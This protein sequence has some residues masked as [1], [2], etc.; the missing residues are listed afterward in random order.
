MLPTQVNSAIQT[1]VFPTQNIG[2]I[3]QKQ[4]QIYSLLADAN[5]PSPTKKRRRKK[6]TKL[7]ET[8]PVMIN[9]HITRAAMGAVFDAPHY[10]STIIPDSIPSS[11]PTC[12]SNGHSLPLR[13]F[14]DSN[15]YDANNNINHSRIPSPSVSL[16]SSS[17]TPAQ[18][19]SAWHNDT[20]SV[21][22][23]NLM[24]QIG[25]R[26]LPFRMNQLLNNNTGERIV[27][28][29]SPHQNEHKH[30]NSNFMVTDQGSLLGPSYSVPTLAASVS[31]SAVPQKKP[32][33]S[34][35]KI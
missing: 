18:Q 35:Q 28:A 32:K 1:D 30:L 20:L 12:L 7:D 4:P 24:P 2:L 23:A 9:P 11:I 25:T 21:A 22:N 15:S 19:I 31:T 8:I 16:N 26:T 10:R 33:R 14:S 17:Q 3:E 29:S 5:T 34:K 13:F 27:A 6:T